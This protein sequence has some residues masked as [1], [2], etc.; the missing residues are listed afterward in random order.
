M[1]GLNK[2]RVSQ[3]GRESVNDKSDVNVKVNFNVNLN[4]NRQRQL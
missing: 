1:E 2:S 4:L 3:I